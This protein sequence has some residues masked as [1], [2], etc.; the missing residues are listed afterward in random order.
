MVTTVSVE[1]FGFMAAYSSHRQCL[2]MRTNEIQYAPSEETG[3]I[4]IESSTAEA[5]VTYLADIVSSSTKMPFSQY[6]TG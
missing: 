6:P 1:V 2:R 4:N 5:K 3:G